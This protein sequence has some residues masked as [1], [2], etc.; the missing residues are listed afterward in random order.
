MN[1]LLKRA[2]RI[3]GVVRVV[4]RHLT[5]HLF[6]CVFKGDEGPFSTRF[7]LILE[8]L[9]PLFVKFGQ[10]MST[11]PDLL[12]SNYL[13]E[14]SKLQDEV[15]PFDSESAKKIVEAELGKS[16]P[17]LFEDFD[18]QPSASAS[19]AQVHKAT[20]NSGEEVA[21]KVRRPNIES[22]IKEDMDTLY[23]LS[24]I[25]TRYIKFFG[26]LR[27]VEAANEFK[28]IVQMEMDFSQEADN[29]NRLRKTFADYY[30]LKIPQVYYATP[31][32][33]ILEWIQGI[34]I[35][36][37]EKLLSA[38]YDPAD[39]AH[40]IT[41]VWIDQI[42]RKGMFHADPHPGNIL[43]LGRRKIGLV[44]MGLIGK[45]NKVDQ[46]NMEDLLYAVVQKDADQILRTLA[47]MEVFNQNADRGKL[48]KEVARLLNRYYGKPLR[49]MNP[50]NLLYEVMGRL[51]RQYDIDPPIRFITLAKTL[52]TL[53]AVCEGLDP[54]YHWSQVLKKSMGSIYLKKLVSS[55]LLDQ[56]IRLINMP[57]RVDRILKMVEEGE[58]STG[59]SK[60]KEML[61]EAYHRLG[62]NL[63]FGLLTFS[64]FM[65][66]TLLILEKIGPLWKGLSILGLI[67]Y[68]AGGAVGVLL[69]TRFFIS[70]KIY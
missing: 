20:L 5:L 54:N 37:K 70:S 64:L 2:K 55:N 31:R 58:L 62:V 26:K 32:L 14:L 17:D 66:S 38:G 49:E 57:Q 65:G 33:L 29:I 10:V 39:L 28:R 4:G 41:K 50:G 16:I 69:L 1:L 24:A 43:V 7:R 22:Q 40:L 36:K 11:R 63:S 52:L 67:G 27:L 12:P 48:R 51:F 47:G 30:R 35:G 46:K 42:F 68:L 61:S 53:E 23:Y 18:P 9:G 45:L 6:R 44:D 56:L 19:L 21:V 15:T 59:S 60:D 13:E 3:L 8:E 34:K 25:L